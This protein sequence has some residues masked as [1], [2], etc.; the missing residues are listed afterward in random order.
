MRCVSARPIM[1]A[2]ETKSHACHC[3]S[4]ALTLRDVTFWHSVQATVAREARA[5]FHAAPAVIVQFSPI[6]L[7]TWPISRPRRANIMA[8]HVNGRI[9]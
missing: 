4:F 5:P 8:A 2:G 7:R 3:G 1:A 9:P 6:T